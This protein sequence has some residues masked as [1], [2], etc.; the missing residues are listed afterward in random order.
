MAK[1]KQKINPCR[2]NQQR[3]CYWPDIANCRG[4]NITRAKRRAIK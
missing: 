1:L 2:Q 4:L 3:A